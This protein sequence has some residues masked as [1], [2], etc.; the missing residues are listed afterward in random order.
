MAHSPNGC[1]GGLGAGYVLYPVR[2]GDYQVGSPCTVGFGLEN[3]TPGKVVISP[4]P[5]HGVFELKVPSLPMGGANCRIVNV[6]GQVVY[7]EPLIDLSQRIQLSD[8][9]PGLYWI[10]ISGKDGEWWEVERVVVD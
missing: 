1:T 9:S 6:H 8:V 7:A 10:L 4:N 5:N 2:T 3:N